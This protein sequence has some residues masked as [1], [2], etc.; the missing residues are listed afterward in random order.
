MHN[1]LPLPTRLCV[2]KSYDFG[3]RLTKEHVAVSTSSVSPGCIKPGTSNWTPFSSVQLFMF[4]PSAL[5]PLLFASASITVSSTRS[6][7][8]AATTAPSINE[9]TTGTF[10]HI[11]L[12]SPPRSFSSTSICSNVRGSM[13][14][15]RAWSVYRYCIERDSTCL[16]ST[17]SS[18]ENFSDPLVPLNKSR[19]S[20][21]TFPAW[22]ARPC[23]CVAVTTSIVLPFNEMTCPRRSLFASILAPRASGGNSETGLCISWFMNSLERAR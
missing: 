11:H 20:T 2:L 9:S 18:G 8:A 4:L 13:S 12:R 15:R 3:E 21:C 5:A 1:L 10:S 16:V 19:N 6:G 23:V 7:T 14:T 17:T 22:R